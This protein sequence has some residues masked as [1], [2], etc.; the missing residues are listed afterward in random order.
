MADM[1]KRTLQTMRDEQHF[2][3]FW[4]KVKRMA[5]DKD[6][7]DPVLP[8]KRKVPQHFETGNAPA[9]FPSTAKDHYRRIF[10]KA[11]DLLVQAIA[12]RFDQPGY[13]TY[14]S[15]Q[16]LILKAV[17]KED[18][19]EELSVVCDLYGSDLHASNLQQQLEILGSNISGNNQDIVEIKSYLQKLSVS[20]RELLTEV[21]LLMNLTPSHFASNKCH[22]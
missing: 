17:K 2:N 18:F 10:F 9:E 4:E 19:S 13:R 5:D 8:R 1:T 15:L 20:E 22:Q 14:H 6:V 12:D 3:L 16:A 7:N 11:L 21:V